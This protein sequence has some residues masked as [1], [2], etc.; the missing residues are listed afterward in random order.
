MNKPDIQGNKFIAIPLKQRVKTIMER[1][2]LSEYAF[3]KALGYATNS[4]I[5]GVLNGGDAQ[6]STL[7]RIL[8]HFPQ[9]NPYFLMTGKGP[10]FGTDEFVRN[11][12]IVEKFVTVTPS[13]GSSIVLV[14][15]KAAA[16]YAQGIR[17]VEYV[18]TL[19]AFNLP[20]FTNDTFRAFEIEGDSMEPTLW[21]GD[22]MICT[23]L[24]SLDQVREGYVHVV[25][26]K[27]GS[28]VA[29]RAMKN[30][31]G[32]IL[33]SDNRSYTPKVIAIEDIF[34]IWKG[35]ARL[36]RYMGAPQN[37]DVRLTSLEANFI[38]LAKQVNESLRKKGT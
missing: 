33:K 25:V 9:V 27:D 19:P 32:L 11:V 8:N 28:I 15:Q 16:G 22:W 30:D 38:E 10:V 13:G 14:D 29:K 36:T 31:N 17:D 21:D 37:V 34:E 12:D 24:E 35:V 6:F 23:Q 18:E 5:R 1:L 4:T 7:D 20:G 3:A 2:N 26:M